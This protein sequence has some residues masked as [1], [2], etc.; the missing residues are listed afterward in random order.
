MTL[1]HDSTITKLYPGALLNEDRHIR[2]LLLQPGETHASIQCQLISTKIA[3]APSYEALS[4]VWGDPEDCGPIYISA[5]GTEEYHEYHVRGT[6]LLLSS[7]FALNTDLE[8]C[9]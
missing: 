9:G 2:L 7:A 6:A 4:Y 1:Q 8:L 3:D 5:P